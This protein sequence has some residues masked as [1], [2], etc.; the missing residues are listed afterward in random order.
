MEKEQPNLQEITA[1]KNPRQA[2]FLTNNRA[3]VNGESGCSIVDLNTKIISKDAWQHLTMHPNKTTFALYNTEKIEI[4]DTEANN[5]PYNSIDLSETRGEIQSI[6]FDQNN[7]IFVTTQH[8]AFPNCVTSKINYK[9]SFTISAEFYKNSVGSGINHILLYHPTKQCLYQATRNCPS[10]ISTSKSNGLATSKHITILQT[11]PCCFECSPDGSSM[12][13]VDLKSLYILDCNHPTLGDQY[14]RSE[15]SFSQQNTI[16][17]IAFHPNSSY[18]AIVLEN[19]LKKDDKKI[20]IKYLETKRNNIISTTRKENIITAIKDNSF[21][22]SIPDAPSSLSFDRDGK[23]ILVTIYNKCFS[24]PVSFEV[25]YQDDAKEKSAFMHWLLKN[26]QID[27]NTILP[28]DVRTI[29]TYFFLE[30]LK[31]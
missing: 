20:F 9:D 7:T 18:I 27:D 4:F 10:L 26:Y 13:I 11:Y 6:I 16:L 15:I 1:I 17:N 29:I 23:H 28:D 14:S 5:E 8:N 31:R 22:F 25:I 3:V 21:D 19:S 12:A 30:M 24:V 2:F